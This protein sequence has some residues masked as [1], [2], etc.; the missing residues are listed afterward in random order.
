MEKELSVLLIED[1]V[2]EREAIADYTA[3]CNDIRLCGITNNS[4]EALEMTAHALPD[5]VILDLELHLGGGNGF[6]YLL[7]LKNLSLPYKPY[8]LITTNNSSNMSLEYTRR[9]GSDFIIS[10]YEVG[11]SAQYVIDFL[12]MLKEPIL[13]KRIS[14]ENTPTTE[15]TQHRERKLV[16]RI[17]RELNLIGINPKNVGY[18]YLVDAI[19]ITIQKPEVNISTI[20]AEKYKKSDASVERAIQNAINRAWRTC[21]IDEL[22][23]HY[24]AKVRSDKGVPTIMEFVYYYARLIQSSL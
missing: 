21:D 12:R 19:L 11:Y 15:S 16:Q 20:I 6:A 4:T 10:K 13:E 18:Q 7:G 14:I 5:A 8:I 24:T 9:L 22:Q 2:Q 1:D 17:Q 23:L 3:S